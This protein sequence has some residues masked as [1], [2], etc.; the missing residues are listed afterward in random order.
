MD[1]SQDIDPDLPVNGKTDVTRLMPLYSCPPVADYTMALPYKMGLN[2]TMKDMKAARYYIFSREGS[3]LPGDSEESGSDARSSSSDF[4][5]PG[6][7]EGEEEG[8]ISTAI[9]WQ[10]H[11]PSYHAS[12]NAP[13][14]TK[15]LLYYISGVTISAEDF[16]DVINHYNFIRFTILI[17]L[18]PLQHLGAFIIASP[19]H[20]ARVSI[21]NL[22]QG[23][24]NQLVRCNEVR[25]LASTGEKKSGYKPVLQPVLST[26]TVNIIR[27]PRKDRIDSG[28]LSWTGVQGPIANNFTLLRVRTRKPQAGPS[29]GTSRFR[30][31]DSILCQTLFYDRVLR[32][33]PKSSDEQEVYCLHQRPDGDGTLKQYNMQGLECREREL[34]RVPT[35]ALLVRLDERAA[36]LIRTQKTDDSK[37]EVTIAASRVDIVN[38]NTKSLPILRGKEWKTICT[39]D[40]DSNLPVIRSLVY[41]ES[42]ALEHTATEAVDQWNHLDAI[43][44]VQKT[45]PASHATS[46]RKSW[47]SQTDPETWEDVPGHSHDGSGGD[48]T[49]AVTK[50]SKPSPSSS[51]YAQSYTPKDTRLEEL[52]LFC[53]RCTQQ[54]PH[55]DTA[56][57]LQHRSPPPPRS[58]GRMQR[59]LSRVVPH[60]GDVTELLLPRSMTGVLTDPRLDGKGRCVCRLI[61]AR[62]RRSQHPAESSECSNGATWIPSQTVL[63]GGECHTYSPPHSVLLFIDT[64]LT[65][66]GGGMVSPV[67]TRTRGYTAGT[68]TKEAFPSLRHIP[69]PDW[70]PSRRPVTSDQQSSRDEK[71]WF[72]QVFLLLNGRGRLKVYGTVYSTSPRHTAALWARL[73][74]A[75][76]ANIGHRHVHITFSLGNDVND[77]FV[78]DHTHGDIERTAGAYPLSLPNTANVMVDKGQQHLLPTRSHAGSTE[79][80]TSKDSKPNVHVTGKLDKMRMMP[81]EESTMTGGAPTL[82]DVMGVQSRGRFSWGN[83]PNVLRPDSFIPPTTATELSRQ[84]QCP[85]GNWS[86]FLGYAPSLRQRLCV[87]VK[88]LLQLYRFKREKHIIGP[89]KIHSSN[90]LSPFLLPR[91]P[92]VGQQPDHENYTGSVLV[93][94]Y[95]SDMRL[96]YVELSCGTGVANQACHKWQIGRTKS[97][98]FAFTSSQ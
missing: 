67:P 98:E 83:V 88:M 48:L 20:L 95:V 63:G 50:S 71:Q 47:V 39:P 29:L 40:R 86:L 51:L 41:C 92:P 84:G 93:Y 79:K 15:Q 37:N 56:T 57:N 38:H 5:T 81:N 12:M 53:L 18:P 72:L 90:L 19:T 62:L 34:S 45:S 46:Q 74:R 77:A 54:T 14:L 9:T 1:L 28:R 87:I 25:M 43:G 42:S 27:V 30:F 26:H 35:D 91:D 73:A 69:L 7:E 75:S 22:C 60:V 89:D 55:H 4:T 58:G 10:T 49:P 13:E 2:G 96:Y 36:F 64:P 21:S 23:K 82:S 85:H 33:V 61:R 65:G 76:H 78:K 24:Y 97:G 80:K 59:L 17:P 32:G 44:R 8:V 52:F 31:G 11:I 68:S 3:Y 6:E 66:H 70:P 16:Y 94:G